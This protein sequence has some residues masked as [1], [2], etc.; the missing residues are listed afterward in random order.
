LRKTCFGMFSVLANARI[1]RFARAQIRL[2]PNLSN[3]GSFTDPWSANKKAPEVGALLLADRE[4]SVLGS[5]GPQW[6]LA[7]VS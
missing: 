4:F 7:N 1:T 2:S 3:K 6:G 5:H